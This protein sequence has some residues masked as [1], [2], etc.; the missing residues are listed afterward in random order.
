MSEIGSQGLPRGQSDISLFDLLPDA[1]VVSDMEGRIVRVNARAQSLFGYSREELLGQ[2]V[3]MLVPERFRAA[4]AD[5]RASYYAEPHTRP[6]GLGMDLRARHKDGSEI[7]V[8][9]S[10]SS[11]KQNGNLFVI[12][13][14]RDQTYLQR[15]EASLR[16]NQRVLWTLMSNLPGMVYRCKNDP[17]WTLEFTNEGCFALTGHSPADF[18]EKKT[19]SYGD[20]IHPVDRQRVWDEV[21]SAVQEGKAFELVYRITTADGKL[22]WVWERGTGIFST[23]GELLALEGFITDITAQQQAERQLQNLSRQ[24]MAAQ[25]NERRHLARELHDEM[26]QLLTGLKLKLGSLGSSPSESPAVLASVSDL[27]DELIAKLRNL[28]FSLRPSMLDDLGLLPALQWHFKQYT[29]QTG[30]RVD[31]HHQR[32]EGRFAPDV[33][34]AAYRILQEALTNVARHAGVTEVA[35]RLYTDAEKLHIDIR[36]DGCGFDAQSNATWQW[37]FGLSGMR[38]RAALLNGR[39]I[40]DSEPGHGTSIIAEIPLARPAAIVKSQE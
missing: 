11:Y 1:I 17:E 12:S 33:E 29:E 31:F 14:V 25:E 2:P 20:L 7:P 6:I 34:T 24:L 39:L 26:G 18:I 4:H 3:D 19:V 37:S 22:K 38:E 5:H 28:A 21:Q 16:E 15:L 27:I 36:D 23:A 10:L 8:A 40:V 30:V 32:M 35:V 9:I 13:V